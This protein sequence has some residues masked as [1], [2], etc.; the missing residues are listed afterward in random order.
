MNEI[1]PALFYIDVCINI[2]VGELRMGIYC[3]SQPVYALKL[4]RV[5]NVRS[6]RGNDVYN[7]RVNYCIIIPG[8]VYTLHK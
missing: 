6:K 4:V 1:L 2:D 3:R 5:D 7:A 8:I